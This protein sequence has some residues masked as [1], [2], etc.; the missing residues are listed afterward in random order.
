MQYTEIEDMSQLEG[1][2]Q[3][4]ILLQSLPVPVMLG[5]VFGFH[6]TDALLKFRFINLIIREIQSIYNVLE[7]G[8]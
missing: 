8:I 3:H 4:F 2:S 1:R 5:I 6:I 7:P